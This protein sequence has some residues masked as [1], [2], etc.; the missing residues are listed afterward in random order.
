MVVNIAL[1]LCGL[2]NMARMAM[3]GKTVT[4]A[5]IDPIGAEQKALI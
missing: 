5:I 2:G 3:F 1:S 4:T